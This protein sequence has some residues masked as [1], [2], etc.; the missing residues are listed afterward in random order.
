MVELYRRPL[1]FLKHA[2]VSTR[3]LENMI[4]FGGG[5]MVNGSK[6]RGIPG[7][8]WGNSFVRRSSRGGKKVQDLCEESAS[9]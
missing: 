4:K 8:K 7:E 3:E 1:R 2:N 5:R 9:E 6:G